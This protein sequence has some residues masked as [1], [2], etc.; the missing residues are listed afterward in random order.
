MAVKSSGIEVVCHLLTT[1][2]V[3]SRGSNNWN[4]GTTQCG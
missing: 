2:R 3:V 4:R 1:G